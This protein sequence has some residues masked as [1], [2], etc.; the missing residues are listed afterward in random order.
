[1]SLIETFRVLTP[2]HRERGIRD[3][4]SIAAGVVDSNTTGA[5]PDSITG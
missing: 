2:R 3:L 5:E 4:D 1:M